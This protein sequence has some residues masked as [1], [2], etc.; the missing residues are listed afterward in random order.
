M[1]PE[2]EPEAYVWVSPGRQAGQPCVGGTRIPTEMVAGYVW[3]GLW[4]ELGPGYEL[5]DRQVLVCCW[6]EAEF[7]DKKWRDRWG[8]W[9]NYASPIL[10]HGHGELPM[11]PHSD[12]MGAGLSMW[13]PC[14]SC[15][16]SGG[17]WLAANDDDTDLAAGSSLHPGPTR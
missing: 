10:W 17:D 6:Y 3:E 11:R 13:S 2:S 5:T 1:T 8:P 12:A 15:A 7:G 4:G 14:V 16:G 9:A